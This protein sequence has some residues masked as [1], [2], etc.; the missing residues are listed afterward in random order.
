MFRRVF[1]GEITHEENRNLKDLT[2]REVWAVLPLA[3]IAFVI[4]IFPNLFLKPMTADSR[5]VVEMMDVSAE[6]AI[7]AQA[8]ATGAKPAKDIRQVVIARFGGFE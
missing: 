1:Y 7:D 2:P 4:G 5:Q 3:V 6:T 8:S